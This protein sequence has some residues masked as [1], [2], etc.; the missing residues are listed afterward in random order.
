MVEEPEIVSGPRN[1]KRRFEEDDAYENEMSSEG[2][3]DLKS[4]K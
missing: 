1:R 2:E 3:M 4:S